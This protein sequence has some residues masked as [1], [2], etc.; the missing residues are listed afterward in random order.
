M[1]LRSVRV[2]EEQAD[3]KLAARRR[4]QE[5]LRQRL[6]NPNVRMVG[7]DTEALKLQMEEKQQRN[8]EEK[9]DDN[10]CVF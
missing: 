3:Q 2:R 5:A 4:E 1:D 8:A 9:A 6:L 10:R 7:R